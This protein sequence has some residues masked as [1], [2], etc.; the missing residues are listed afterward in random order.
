MK[1]PS[2][3][4]VETVQNRDNLG[5]LKQIENLEHLEKLDVR[6]LGLALCHMCGMKRNSCRGSLLSPGPLKSIN[7]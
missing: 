4:V 2:K 5:K 6:V 3:Q 7:N 1:D